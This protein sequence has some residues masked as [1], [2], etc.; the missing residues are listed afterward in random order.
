MRYLKQDTGTITR[1]RFRAAGATMGQ[2]QE[3]GESL[4]EDLVGFYPLDVDH[5]AHAAGIVLK[6][7]VVQPLSRGQSTRVLGV[8]LVHSGPP[9]EKQNTPTVKLHGNITV[10]VIYNAGKYNT[11]SG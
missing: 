3:D 6:S 2:V 11:F 4:A 7:W 9:P 5:K 10:G 1:V 8:T